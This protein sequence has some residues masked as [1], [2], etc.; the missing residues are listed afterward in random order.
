MSSVVSTS[1]DAKVDAVMYAAETDGVTFTD[2]RKRDLLLLTKSSGR[3]ILFGTERDTESAMAIQKDSVRVNAA[4]LDVRGA[5]TVPSG[6]LRVKE[7]N[8][9]FL[10][11]DPLVA[12]CGA[13]VARGLRVIREEEDDDSALLWDTDASGTTVYGGLDARK[14]LRVGSNLIVEGNVDI[15]GGR[16]LN[17]ELRLD[18]LEV[19]GDARVSGG[20]SAG[21]NDAFR[22]LPGPSPDVVV[23]NALRVRGQVS[24]DGPVRFTGGSL[25]VSSS[26]ALLFDVGSN[27]IALNRD[28]LL[29]RDLRV[30]GSTRFDG[31]ARFFNDVHVE[32]GGGFRVDEG[33]SILRGTLEVTP[34]PRSVTAS[35]AFAV[36]DSD[37]VARRNLDA[38]SNLAVSGSADVRGALRVRGNSGD[39][40][41][42]EADA[43]RVAVRRRLDI[44]S[45]SGL[46]TEGLAHLRGGLRVG[47]TDDIT[48]IAP[49]S[50]SSNIVV[51]NRDVDARCN[52]RVRG[53]RTDL[54]GELRVAAEARLEKGL[55]VR[56]GSAVVEGGGL[57]VS[58]VGAFA[59]GSNLLALEVSDAGVRALRET[60]V[61]GGGSLIVRGAGALRAEGDGG[62]RV[63][64]GGSILDGDFSAAGG[65]L[66]ARTTAT[67]DGG[68]RVELRENTRIA[69]NL[70][71]S[72]V[73]EAR[74]SFYVNAGGAPPDS[75]N[76][77]VAS[78]A[79]IEMRRDLALL[80][81]SSL[82]V[83]G[84]ST[85]VGP[86]KVSNPDALDLFTVDTEEGVRVRRP[87]RV[88]GDTRV[89]GNLSVN[90]GGS[91]ALELREPFFDVRRA[92]GFDCNV[93]V[94]GDLVALGTRVRF[95]PATE[96]GTVLDVDQS[97]VRAYRDLEAKRNLFV[98]GDTRLRGALRLNPGDRDVLSVTPPAFASSNNNN[99]NTRAGFR[100]DG[101][102]AVFSDGNLD[103][104]RGNLSVTGE[105]AVRPGGLDVF[106]ATEE[107]VVANRR[108]EVLGGQELIGAF[109]VYPGP[110]AAGA[111]RPAFSVSDTSSSSTALVRLNRDVE[112][113]CNLDVR[114]DVRARG[115]MALTGGLS[116]D[117]SVNAEGDFR[118]GGKTS[119]EG[120]ASFYDGVTMYRGKEGPV[121]ASVGPQ[122]CNLIEL[123]ASNVRLRTLTSEES[124][125]G[126]FDVR[127]NADFARGKFRVLR[128]SGDPDDLAV[129]LVKEDDVTVNAETINL[130]GKVGVEGGEFS[131]KPSSSS[132]VAAAVTDAEVALRRDVRARCNLEVA[133]DLSVRG[134]AEVEG[135]LEARADVTVRG[136]L[137]VREN[138]EVLRGEATFRGGALRVLDE[139][140]LLASFT[141][142]GGAEIATSL[143]VADGLRLKKGDLAVE[144]GNLTVVPGGNAGAG[145]EAML[146]NDARVDV[147]RRFSVR[148]G[149]RT[150]LTG[151]L[152][153]RGG[154]GVQD[155]RDAVATFS[156]AS[157]VALR[158]D[159]FAGSN[160]RVGGALEVLGEGGVRLEEKLD[161]FTLDS[162]GTGLR[163]SAFRVRHPQVQVNRRLEA[164]CNVSVGGDLHVD[165]RVTSDALEMN[166]LTVKGDAA[167]TG[168]LEVGGDIMTVFDDEITIR[169]N[170]IMRSNVD[171]GRDLA[172]GGDV[173][174]LGT[175]AVR[176]G[177]PEAK[178]ALSVT[179]GLTT[180]DTDLTT[181]SNV[182]IGRDVDLGRDLFV[183][184]N[185]NI[186]GGLTVEGGRLVARRGLLVEGDRTAI[187]TND[188]V[189]RP[190]GGLDVL[191]VSPSN[192]EVARP[193]SVTGDVDVTGRFVVTEGGQTSFA[194]G[195]TTTVINRDLQVNGDFEATGEGRIGQDL[196]VGGSIY[197]AGDMVVEGTFT[198]GK[199]QSDLLDNSD[200][201][202]LT[203][204][205]T[206]RVVL[207]GQGEDGED[208]VALN[209]DESGV[210][211]GRNLEV[212][213]DTL[214]NGDL[215]IVGENGKTLFELLDE[216]G[217][218]F[219]GEDMR[220]DG[221]LDVLDGLRVGDDIEVGGDISMTGGDG[222]FDASSNLVKAREVRI[223]DGGFASSGDGG[224]LGDFVVRPG[225]EETSPSMLD[226]TSDGV[227]VGGDLRA[228]GDV[229]AGGALRAAGTISSVIDGETFFSTG[230]GGTDV[231][232]GLR[233]E[234]GG[235]S[236]SGGPFDVTVD[237]ESS[238]VNP[239][240][241]VTDELVSLNRD[242]AVRG[243]L[244][245]TGDVTFEG[246][247][248]TNGDTRLGG[249]LDIGDS[250][251]LASN[252]TVDGTADLNSNLVVRTGSD[253]RVALEVRHTGID[254]RRDVRAESNIVIGRDVTVGRDAA[255]IGA[256]SVQGG[257]VFN[258]SSAVR[259]QS[260]Q[261]RA[262]SQ[263]NTAAEPSY[264]WTGDR[265]TGMYRPSAN[266]IAFTTD[267]QERVRIT[268]GG[269]VGFG[270]TSPE[271]RLDVGDGDIR[272]GGKISVG[273]GSLVEPAFTFEGDSNTG[274]YR[275]QEGD[276]GFSIGGQEVFTVTEEGATF[277]DDLDMSGQILGF[278]AGDATRPSFAF[279]GDTD[280][281]LFRSTDAQAGDVLG[282][283]T[284]GVE[285]A[286]LDASGNLGLGRSPGDDF[287]LDVDGN[288]RVS[289][290]R[291]FAPPEFD[292]PAAPVITWTG[293]DDTGIYRVAPDTVGVSTGGQE[294]LR[295]AEDGRV[296]VN[297]P[298][299]NDP[300]ARLHVNG[301]FLATDRIATTFNGSSAS[302]AFAFAAGGT[303]LYLD[304]D[305]VNVT[306]EGSDRFSVTPDG[307]GILTTDPNAAL[308]VISPVI[309]GDGEAKAVANLGGYRV[310][311]LTVDLLPLT[312]GAYVDLLEVL[313][314]GGA[315][316]VRLDVCDDEHG[317]GTLAST[318]L[319]TAPRFFGTSDT[320]QLLLPQSRTCSGAL[321]EEANIDPYQI[322]VAG[323]G[324]VKTLLFRLVRTNS[325]SAFIGPIRCTFFVSC[326]DHVT[327]ILRIGPFSADGA[328]TPVL[329]DRARVANA[330]Q[331]TQIS[332]SSANDGAAFVG[333][334]VIR[335]QKKFH[336]AG[337]DARF[338]GDVFGSR[339]VYVRDDATE[340]LPAFSFEG[341][342]DTGI[343]R[344]DADEIAITV[345][346]SEGLRLT[347]DGLAIGKTAPQD[348][349]DVVG[350][351][352]ATGGRF[353]AGDEGSEAAPSFAWIDDKD[354]GVYLP[355]DDTLAVT[356]GGA[357]RVRVDA[358]GNVGI[359]LE[360]LAA[361]ARLHVDGG[362]LATDQV[363]TFDGSVSAPAF[364]FT[365][366]ADTGMFLGR[367]G[368][369]DEPVLELALKGEEHTVFSS[370]GVGIFVSE[371]NAALQVNG[372][373]NSDGQRVFTVIVDPL[374]TTA[375]RYV[376]LA[377]LSSA[378]EGAVVRVDVCDDPWTN[379][380]SSTYLY[381]TDLFFSDGD[382]YQ[383]LIPLSR[384]CKGSYSS[385]NLNP[386]QLQVGSGGE[387][388]ESM[389]TLN[390]RLV[391][392][393]T[394]GTFIGPIRCTFTV[395]G[396]PANDASV[397]A[398]G[399]T[400]T[401][402]ATTV[403]NAQ[404]A[405]SSLI[406]NAT[407]LTQLS[408]VDRSAF[409][410]IGVVDPQDK[411]HV[412][413][414]DVRV[415]GNVFSDLFRGSAS[416]SAGAPTFSF[417]G[418][419]D[420][421]LYRPAA[422]EL[423]LSS[424]GSNMVRLKASTGRL[425]VGKD[426][427]QERLDVQGNVRA[428]SG[429]FIAGT[430]GSRTMP[431]FRWLD[432][433]DT[434]MYRPGA[435][436]L[437][438]ATGGLERVSVTEDGD[439]G[440]NQTSPDARLHV[441][442]DILAT[443][444]VRTF[445]DGAADGPG[446][447]FE[448][449]PGTGLFTD[450][451][452]VGGAV[453]MAV[454]L[455][456]EQHTTFTSNGVGIFTADPD[457]TLHVAGDANVGGYRV[458]NV[459]VE[460]LGLALE[461]TVE[462]LEIRESASSSQPPW[463]TVV[464]LDV[465]EQRN[466]SASSHTL[467]SSYH[468][469]VDRFFDSDDSFENENK[470][471]LPTSRTSTG[472]YEVENIN[473]YQVQVGRGSSGAGSLRFL[474]VR[475]STG[476]LFEGVFRCVFRV[477]GNPGDDPG[478]FRVGPTEV[479]FTDV[480]EPYER[481]RFVRST[482]V[483][484]ITASDRVAYVGIG[485]AMPEHRLHVAGTVKIDSNLIVEE[486][487]I[488]RGRIAVM[489]GAVS[490]GLEGRGIHLNDLD[491]TDW[492]LYL[493][494]TVSLAG[495]SAVTGDGFSGTSARL[496]IR[497]RGD[498][499]LILENSSEERLL[500]V[501]GDDGR[502]VVS[503]STV[504]TDTLSVTGDVNME[505]GLTVEEDTIHR[506]KIIVMDGAINDG[507]NG[508]G[509]H[510]ADATDTD[511]G[512][513]LNR[514]S[515]AGGN[516]V[517]GEG[518][519]GS[520]VRLRIR[521]A[522]DNGLV[523]ENSTE[524]RL[525]S[526]RGNDGYMSIEGRL[527]CASDAEM[528]SRLTVTGDMINTAKT[529]LG[530]GL[531]LNG[532]NDT[533]WGIYSSSS[534]SLSGSSV[535]SGLGFSGLATRIRVR[536][537]SSTGLI[538]ENSSETRLLSIRGND[539]F[540]GINGDV[541]VSGSLTVEGT[542]LASL[543]GRINT[544]ESRMSAVEKVLDEDIII[545]QGI[546]GF[547]RS[548]LLYIK[549]LAFFWYRHSS[550]RNT[551]S[552][553]IPS[554]IMKSI[555]VALG[556][557]ESSRGGSGDTKT[558]LRIHISPPLSLRFDH[559]SYER[560]VSVLLIGERPD[561]DN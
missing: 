295:V 91:T 126:L 87:L 528:L 263:L 305:Q 349:L 311:T 310:A 326:S 506:G 316:A 541:N 299:N 269:D 445:E 398:I 468:Y 105:L 159:V 161:V 42:L 106:R 256:L 494:D 254:L 55:S 478:L 409:V 46:S 270:V 233:V 113:A 89:E 63:T 358:D 184:R 165:G 340:A 243:D 78:D 137:V 151:D 49:P 200:G 407:Q 433:E 410:G 17:S 309:D 241:S 463:G 61:E 418:D 88:E 441:G 524:Q 297:M 487:T 77:M 225:G 14:E 437:A 402:D 516:G 231:K 329:T 490:G 509:I 507:V 13:T 312:P 276:I 361:E 190:G 440:I 68:F 179:P 146:V 143:E 23:E 486:D 16:L 274:I 465:C 432:D 209:A 555:R 144:S 134:D 380:L 127:G 232:N 177:G 224:V 26:N 321:S 497:D 540:T 428:S 1:D 150:E 121:M 101:A 193:L 370:N 460:E 519:G 141:D 180:M 549:Q 318:Y 436:T 183:G 498:A 553:T 554:S 82:R 40:V 199:M 102:D 250:L 227:D 124:G 546:L 202:N 34:D 18:R 366:G 536:N 307:V 397:I 11:H 387:G 337:G 12:S 223:G 356:T 304:G 293:D 545:Q 336:V 172:V 327:D 8:L 353:L 135:R 27:N 481:E 248:T 4:L 2:A 120:A 405:S 228:E 341:D 292:S 207:R 217:R 403:I 508:R 427:P 175:L 265:D 3:S 85:F 488:H 86:F 550:G 21:K 514:A 421:G 118:V 114:G 522:S 455:D 420:T 372:S 394:S 496:R 15:R 538:V 511:W 131:V 347:S 314:E 342:E 363:R 81:G 222:V 283:S 268:P 242:T 201:S 561:N 145:L 364:S 484:Q 186:G 526:I 477:V 261:L 500:S 369:D 425:G 495:N 31:T 43:T 136:D 219:M 499:G 480:I 10:L 230:P 383:L 429:A 552:R 157:N 285:R 447:A 252:L 125:G 272:S 451:D 302:P 278:A 469:T 98:D 332:S 206:L 339:S 57:R 288:L 457:A 346:G 257:A 194:I 479:D 60:T 255:V 160:L 529:V 53:G 301:D 109:N 458:Y 72:G 50:S 29:S 275:T 92:T 400:Y 30:E 462:L 430:D 36:S 153:V 330:T 378:G 182:S 360:G 439:V 205:S 543:I 32:R 417:A 483:T 438:L 117:G 197:G 111:R 204:N 155:A 459:V 96:G 64:K 152:V 414:G 520:A 7:P 559:R 139:E 237:P 80:N 229:D 119:A 362:V 251:Y 422:N 390:F 221:S 476:G 537:N 355:D 171:I 99:N 74:G 502:M 322:Q 386:Y 185:A 284:G 107:R 317:G 188:L 287:R 548:G 392:T 158:R 149:H 79:G 249:S 435:D 331:L 9:P 542:T 104:S 234:G 24:G 491:D 539:G 212:Q 558:N 544:L 373:V 308:H 313:N 44:L 471:L 531:F 54:D 464:Y 262:S 335:P 258:G 328:T 411:L 62:F 359:N 388:S 166:D 525:M 95:V 97:S 215:K 195:E 130:E 169:P 25:S 192:V 93:Q 211:I 235:T 253:K 208:L 170:V 375:G 168:T 122:G 245:A 67:Q 393:G 384:A 216:N 148:D 534:Q 286:R 264:S 333:V 76:V 320:P 52:L 154:P 174:T 238:N 110:Q 319:Y 162:A 306:L 423:A 213:G 51:A 527:H 518:F 365:N 56:G 461:S 59:G 48:F 65:A 156:A 191:R 513:Y 415:D 381:T 452:P 164:A 510:F 505:S 298:S 376:D 512:M 290:G 70:R 218:I 198:A 431:A 350:N 416:A 493:N 94:R 239:T 178:A 389:L 466:D 448:S 357:E 240:V 37:V 344:P 112:A 19:D 173:S 482:Q 128:E 267:G 45:S 442:G 399:P 345:G 367:R 273:D 69:K 289:S 291:I 71:V 196:Y 189:V 556:T 473:P 501:R 379:A 530:T 453:K 123:T 391:R 557:I 532:V 41:V 551:T 115:E 324:S 485:E 100:V 449:H 39:V 133:R 348:A 236:L 351:V 408:A 426:D 142:A 210:E 103:V 434:G 226:V 260:S 277:R 296:G 75:S 354:T 547:D 338:E 517:S 374:P 247:L 220:V 475:T 474:L 352:R 266:A 147:R 5:L 492:G 450:A 244:S 323:T 280:T 138:L 371:P 446:F 246:D 503:G 20:L 35:T 6:S 163:S 560:P 28:A 382:P 271:A 129:L 523:I 38:R 396:C 533:N 521:D 325:G 395:S 404:T 108:L 454:A 368:A 203:L 83:R 401:S 444:Q 535:T 443:G 315:S 406:A 66:A 58:P 116:T 385:T 334:G 132:S 294:R 413:G 281:G 489:D 259:V 33:P 412:A 343:F 187:E 181:R 303:G 515:L 90:T 279:S 73:T 467:T 47:N 176:P 300:Q 84:S 419:T 456:G 470:L 167:V 504:I 22:V 214:L 140:R 472:P 282:F 377:R 424:G